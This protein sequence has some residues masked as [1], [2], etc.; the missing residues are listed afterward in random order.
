M[1]YYSGNKEEIVKLNRLEKDIDEARNIFDQHVKIRKL[2]EYA[3]KTKNID[4]YLA[5]IQHTNNPETTKELMQEVER[6]YPEYYNYINFIKKIMNFNIKL[7][8]FINS[9]LN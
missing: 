1:R 5:A 2:V 9:F 8:N 7:H 6:W 4:V 3:K